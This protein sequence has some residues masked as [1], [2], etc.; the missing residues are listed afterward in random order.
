M[1]RPNI[2]LM[3]SD[4][5]RLDHLGC[6]GNPDI[7]TPNIDRL[8]RDSLLFTNAFPESLPT[9]PVRRALHTGRRAYPFRDYKPVKWDIVYL[10]GWQPMDPDEDTLAENLAGSGYHTGFITDTLPY[11]A[12]GYN[13]RRG[14]YQWDF[15][16]GQ[17]QDRWRSPYSVSAERLRK[18]GATKEDR[19][20]NS[21]VPM[22]LANTAQVRHEEDTS[23]ARTFKSAVKFLE[24]NREAQPFYLLV[25]CF[26]PH[27]PWDAP[28]KY[29]EMYGD[30]DYDGRRL[31]HPRYGPADSCYTDSEVE[32]MAAQ[33]KAHVS[34]VDA[35]MGHFL[36]RLQEL[37]LDHNTAVFLTSDHG[38][39]LTD[40]PKNVVGKP[41]YS[42]YPGVMRLP[43]IARLP[44]NKGRGE[45]CESLVYNHD[46]TATIYDLAG[47][48]PGQP[49]DGQS[50]SPLLTG[51]GDYREREYVTSR[52]ANNLCHIDGSNW[53]ICGIDGNIIHIFDLQEDPG[54]QRDIQEVADPGIFQ[55]A[56]THLL[57]DAGGEFPDYRER[58]STD[59]I[60]REE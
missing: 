6:Y 22:H 21:I 4:T 58:K 40:N 52:Y 5:L 48:E 45:R 50:L 3:V 11:F 33:Y 41:S 15:I 47:V 34:L 49:I 16:R 8:A 59:A 26:D 2:I 32:Y 12:P 24:E 53:V 17:Q 56:W 60:G 31:V 10:P 18:Y 37:G 55:N 20:P 42:L 13:F 35:W 51:E 1:S 25:D 43:L 30:P 7:R 29:Y 28:Q 39:N 38:T 23:T 57:F 9:V 14:F 36:D 27:E 46:I 19:G 44:W 54:C